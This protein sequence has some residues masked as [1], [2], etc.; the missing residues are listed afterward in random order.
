MYQQS[1]KRSF[2]I[3][4]GVFCERA[5]KAGIPRNLKQSGDKVQL[6]QDPPVE[7]MDVLVIQDL[8]VDYGCADNPGSSSGDYGCPGNPSG[9][10]G[11]GIPGSS[12]G[13]WMSW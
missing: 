6:I 4:C 13:L 10:Y 11:C 1:A 8:P 9:D 3:K 12:S 2:G 5:A 7:T